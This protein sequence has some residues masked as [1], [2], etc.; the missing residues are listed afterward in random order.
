MRRQVDR[1]MLAVKGL[2]GWTEYGVPSWGNSYSRGPLAL[3]EVRAPILADV[4]GPLDKAD[5]PAGD[6]FRRPNLDPSL[7]TGNV[8]HCLEGCQGYGGSLEG[9]A[10]NGDLSS[11]KSFDSV[12]V[13]VYVKV[14]EACGATITSR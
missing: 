2:V 9:H 8:R 7:P 5:S 4:S 11:L 14:L 12:G 1:P 10:W 3:E 6:I 13:E